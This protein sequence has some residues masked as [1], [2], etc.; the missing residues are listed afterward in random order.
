M[1]KIP[2]PADWVVTI[3][4]PTEKLK[5][6]YIDDVVNY[7]KDNQSVSSDEQPDIGLTD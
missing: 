6:M 5:Q 3:V 2:V 1:K 4:N 7:G